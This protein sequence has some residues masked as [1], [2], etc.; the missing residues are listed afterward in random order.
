MIFI[1]FIFSQD[2]INKE[3]SKR[4]FVAMILIN[5]IS[6][7]N[8]NNE[9]INKKI[10]HLNLKISDLD[11]QSIKNESIEYLNSKN[12][13]T[14][15]FVYKNKVYIK[16]NR[17]FFRN[18]N[19][20]HRRPPH[21]RMGKDGKLLPPPRRLGPRN[22]EPFR[23]L[24]PIPIVKSSDKILAGLLRNA[25]LLP[26]LLKKDILFE[27]L[28]SSFKE[29][30][31]WFVLFVLVDMVL[32]WF[33]LFLMKK[34]KPLLLLKK[35][36]RNFSN[37]KL[38][39][40]KELIYKDEISEVSNEFN[41]ALI[42]IKE[43]RESRNLFLRNIMHELNTPITKGKLISDTLASSRR[44]EILQKVF[45][46]LEYL[47][48]EFSKIEELTSGKI[49]LK[50]ANYRVLDVLDEAFDLLLLDNNKI[51]V[52]SVD[53]SI[54]VDFQ[55][56]SIA[57]KNLIDN[58]L[59]YNSNGN[60][61]LL[62]SHS[63]ISISNKG[64]ALKKDINEYYKPFNREYESINEGLGLGLYITKNIIDVHGYKL[65]YTYEKGIHTFVIDYKK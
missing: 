31:I 6:N 18:L 49:T 7:H 62:I 2:T 23:D 47:L 57:L 36:I 53:V 16:I 20:K 17:N 59:K 32:L 4:H 52:S 63:S 58:A 60:P 15:N 37:G 9:D 24:F 42:K 1:L 34:L 28:N 26:A 55:I 35:K 39:I 21:L 40:E 13:A 50:R 45:Y 43:L 22:N 30:L 14:I 51:N 44:K 25:P 29:N 5:N 64:R 46:R 12:G 3:R 38:I 8:L 48:I 56:F 10:K 61:E 65:N 33:Y 11:Y 27:D 19:G 54:D 41:N